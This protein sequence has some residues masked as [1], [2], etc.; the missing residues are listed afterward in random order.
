[1]LL[2]EREENL[3]DTYYYASWEANTLYPESWEWAYIA[4]SSTVEDLKSGGSDFIPLKKHWGENI[5]EVE[6]EAME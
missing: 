2:K 5:I 1:M 3:S 6:W 4:P